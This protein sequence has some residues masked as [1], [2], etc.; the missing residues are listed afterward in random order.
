MFKLND[1]GNVAIIVALCL[2]VVVGGAA[3]GIETGFWRYD[4]VRVQQAADAAAYAGAVVDRMEGSNATNAMI[5]DA[6]TNTATQNGYT[7]TTD[8][9]TVNI[10]STTTPSDPNS[11]EAV[12]DRTEPP[13]F[14]AYISCLIAN[15]NN[16]SGTPTV[17]HTRATASFSNAGNACILALSPS[18][19]KA[20]DFAG[21]SALTLSGCSVMSNSLASNAVNVQ[22]S[23]DLTAPCLYAAGGASLGGT[24]DLTTCGAVKTAQ[25]PVA[26]P[27]GGMT[28]PT[29]G[30]AHNFN[31]NNPPNNPCGN[32][33]SGISIKNTWDAN[34]GGA[35]PCTITVS[36]GNL[37]LN[38]SA[39]LTCSNCTFYLTN[40]ASLTMN[41]NAHINLTAEGSGT[42]KGMAIISDRSNNASLQINGDSTSSITG[43]IYAPDGTVSY[44]GNFAGTSGCTQIVAQT[45]SWSG[46]TT[47]SDTCPAGW[48]TVAVGSVVRLSA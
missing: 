33:Y 14:A 2:P 24:V 18:A 29:A 9:I 38:A 30:T 36:G 40:G 28:M 17:V 42:Y 10:P 8:T 39:N 32:T 11:V 5:T 44:I 1:K 25:P 13:I 21:N 7:S 22:G 35:S 46:N 4:Q 20:V 27:F 47:F 41:G 6:A 26:D 48:P 43:N 37:D 16:C 19:S 15:S 3:F 12:I 34:P 31:S 45:V 23:A